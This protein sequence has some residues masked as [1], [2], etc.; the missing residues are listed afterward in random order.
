FTYRPTRAV[1]S[2]QACEASPQLLGWVVLKERLVEKPLGSRLVPLLEQRQRNHLR[3]SK[4][5]G[6]RKPTLRQRPARGQGLPGLQ[7][8]QSNRGIGGVGKRENSNPLVWEEQHLRAESGKASPVGNHPSEL[9][10]FR[11]AP[12]Q[13]ITCRASVDRRACRW[14]VHGQAH[15]TCHLMRLSHRAT[16]HRPGFWIVARR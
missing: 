8:Q 15:L 16:A 3:Q 1:A 4:R 14:S 12:P 2:M 10:G 9:A 6:C 11:R 7:Y 13:S 5:R